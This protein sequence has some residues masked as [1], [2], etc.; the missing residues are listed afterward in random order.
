MSKSCNE[1]LV[2][3]Y[4]Y[5]N[6]NKLSCSFTINDFHEIISKSTFIFLQNPSG[7]GVINID[8]KDSFAWKDK[9]G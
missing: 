5:L 6:Q 9:V 2:M 4:R 3:S 1:N 8:P 7:S